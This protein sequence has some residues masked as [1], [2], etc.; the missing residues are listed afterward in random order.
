[1]DAYFERIRSFGARQELPSRI[2]FMLQDVIDLRDNKV[3]GDVIDLRD[4]KVSGVAG[5]MVKGFY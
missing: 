1:M 4:N 3:S 5:R 2:R